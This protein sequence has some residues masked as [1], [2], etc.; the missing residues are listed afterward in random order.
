MGA[1]KQKWTAEEESAL[2]AGI[3]KHGSGKWRTILRDPEFSGI[4]SLRSNVDLKDKWRNLSVTANG[5]GS[6]EKARIAFKKS[7]QNPKHEDNQMAITTV[8]EYDNEVVDVKPLA[9][10]SEAAQISTPKI[11]E[12]R[13]DDLIIE[14]ITKLKEPT[15]SN[16]TDI[17]MYI[18]DQY[19]APANFKRFLSDK[20]KAMNRSGK[21]IRVNRKYRIAPSSPFS[22]GR[23]S[24]VLFPEGKHRELSRGDRSDFKPLTKSQIDSELARMRNMTAQEAAAAVAQAVAE[25]EIAM[26][27][28]E[29]AAEEAEAAEAEF[30]E[31]QAFAE[32]AKLTLENRNA[33]KKWALQ[34]YS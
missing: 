7:Q 34:S 17:A 30:E 23:S 25:A 16:K 14:A 27:E 28:A 29:A 24:K 9:I 20:L 6:R 3:A 22:E 2:K 11:S 5:W 32:A 33:A 19:E 15:G 8:V 21:L 10:S 1:P 13:L 18:K 12:S 31:A 26:T 4:L